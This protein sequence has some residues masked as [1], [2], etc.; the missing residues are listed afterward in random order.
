MENLIKEMHC[1]LTSQK[2]LSALKIE[3]KRR[4]AHAPRCE[5][6]IKSG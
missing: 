4:G 1:F 6:K 2:S 3:M 5:R